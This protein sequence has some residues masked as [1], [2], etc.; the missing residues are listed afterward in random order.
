MS[1]VTQSKE[2]IVLA[3]SFLRLFQSAILCFNIKWNM[4]WSIAV[5]QYLPIP[6]FLP[7]TGDFSTKY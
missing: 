7:A 1:F 6:K 2:D 4:Q 3:H 5:S